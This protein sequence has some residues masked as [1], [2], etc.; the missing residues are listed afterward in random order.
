MINES[1]R[2]NFLNLQSKIDINNRLVMRKEK[3]RF[4]IL[5]HHTYGK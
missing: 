4:K 1:E 2:E 5:H 3:A